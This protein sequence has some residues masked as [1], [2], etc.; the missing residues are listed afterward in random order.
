MDGGIYADSLALKEPLNVI[1]TSAPNREMPNSQD[2]KKQPFRFRYTV[3]LFV[4]FTIIGLLSSTQMILFLNLVD[5]PHSPVRAYAAIM[6]EWYLWAFMTPVLFWYFKRNS[7]QF[8][9]IYGNLLKLFFFSV[10]V[11]FVKFFLDGL[12]VRLG[13]LSLLGPWIKPPSPDSLSFGLRMSIDLISPKTFVNFLT[14]WTIL[15]VIY[16]WQYNQQL[17]ERELLASRMRAQLTQVQL[18][19]LQMQLQPHFL[20][21]TLHSI[22]SLLHDNAPAA[23]EMLAN[24][25]EMLRKTLD[26]IGV[27]QIPLCEEI[28]LVQTY[29]SIEKV[30]FQ[31]RLNVQIQIDPDVVNA[32]VPNLLLQPLIENAIRHGIAKQAGPGVIRVHA[33]RMTDRVEI[34]VTDNGPGLSDE[35]YDS[36]SEGMGLGITRKR[37]THLHGDSHTILFDRNDRGETTLTIAF[38]YLEKPM[39]KTKRQ[40]VENTF[41]DHER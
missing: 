22:S 38:P 1:D 18:N 14:C 19:A 17:K 5:H 20:F 31:D 21:N 15:A 35:L 29:L 23:D 26:K 9:P 7:I 27:Q 8:Q 12:I 28:D 34:S 39:I 33:R 25:S 4:I 10:L 32:L 16:A 41:S 36:S 24:L 6:L 40:K 2:R 11:V 37:L 3:L 30:R 13:L